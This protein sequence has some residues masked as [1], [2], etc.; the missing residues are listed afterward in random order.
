[1]IDTLVSV[2]LHLPFGLMLAVVALEFFAISRRSKTADEAVIVVLCVAGAG[3][4]LAVVLSAYL[5]FGEGG[6]GTPFGNVW[7][8][9]GAAALAGIALGLKVLCRRRGIASVDFGGRRGRGATRRAKGRSKGE[10]AGRAMILVG[11]RGTL[12]GAVVALFAGIFMVKSTSLVPPVV[13]AGDAGAVPGPGEKPV[14]E[15]EPTVADATPTAPAIDVPEPVASVDPI[16]AEPETVT[17]PAEVAVVPEETPVAPEPE[18]AAVADTGSATVAPEGTAEPAMTDDGDPAAVAVVEGDPDMETGTAPGM[19]EEGSAE[20]LVAKVDP[21]GKTTPAM[22]PTTTPVKPLVPTPAPPGTPSAASTTPD[23]KF[24]TLVLPLIKD[25]C[26]DCHGPDKQKGDLRLD[27][28]EGIRKGGKSGPVVVVGQPDKS[29]MFVSVSLPPDDDDIMPP[30]GKPLTEAQAGY[31]RRWILD[32]ARLGDGQ[33]WPGEDK[34]VSMGGAGDEPLPDGVTMP[35]PAFLEQLRSDGIEVLA[36]TGSGAML[37]IGLTHA[38]R[39]A[40]QMRLDQLAPI[41]KNIQSLDLKKTKVSDDDL[42]ILEDMTSLTKLNLALTKVGDPS[43]SHIRRL[44]DLEYLNLYG[45]EVSD[46]SVTYIKDLKKL[47][48]LFLWNSKVTE[49]GVAKLKKELPKTDI[50]VGG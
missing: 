22:V 48:K 27:T 18:V 15:P 12:A 37:E 38:D 41:V 43:M 16:P 3:L 46:R 42:T 6:T 30:K 5:A 33:K 29:Q 2:L 17:P 45:T 8:G 9:F 36:V 31:I 32:G 28:P 23:P 44:E 24:L 4:L 14:P 47:T 34:F 10:Q 1:V 13:V 19:M 7:I 35:D 25:R 26:F 39:P 20:T 40:G 49:N 11:Y 21:A 50:S